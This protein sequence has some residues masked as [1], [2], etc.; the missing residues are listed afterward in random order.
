MAPESGQGGST[1]I[2]ASAPG[3]WGGSAT[4]GAT[5][6]FVWKT[7]RSSWSAQRREAASVFLSSRSTRSAGG[8][9]GWAGVFGCKRAVD[10]RWR[11]VDCP[12]DRTASVVAII[13]QRVE[14]LARGLEDRG[15][16]VT[17]RLDEW[18]CGAD[19]LRASQSRT[20]REQLDDLANESP[21]PT[22]ELTLRRLSRES[23]QALIQIR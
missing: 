4:S 19:Y 9:G 11:S 10:A 1:I 17:T 6:R 16:T 5:V 2:D 15:R 20:I 23:R 13:E 8:A 22:G 7:P 12:P 14:A 3:V 18:F 21:L